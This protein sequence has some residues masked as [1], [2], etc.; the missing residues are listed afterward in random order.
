MTI[1][2][3]HIKIIDEKH[4]ETDS[5]TNHTVEI[6]SVFAD[7]ALVDNLDNWNYAYSRVGRFDFQ[8][9]GKIEEDHSRVIPTE[10]GPAEIVWYYKDLTD[11]E[12]VFYDP[13]EGAV[14][15]N[16]FCISAD[17]LNWTIASPV[18]EGGDGNRDRHVYTLTG[19]TH[20]SYV[21]TL[22]VNPKASLAPAL[23]R[24]TLMKADK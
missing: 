16:V 5:N 6:A 12:A 14:E 23:S 2:T 24:V 19:L 4:P 22:W 17:G 15:H 9:F 18:V 20:V 13:P 8:Y 10:E 3:L 21:K 11:F 7:G 1:H